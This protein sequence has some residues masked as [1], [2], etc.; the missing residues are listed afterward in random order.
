LKVMQI[1]ELAR[2]TS[3]TVQ[4]IRLYE[5]SGLLK[6]PSRSAGNYRVYDSE[7]LERLVFIRQC[8]ALGISI[9]EIATLLHRKETP[10][11]SC[12]EVNQLIAKHLLK[13]QEKICELQ[14]LQIT[15]EQLS[16][17]CSG[18]STIQTCGIFSKLEST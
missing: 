15:L 8:R 11:E 17:E 4:T 16:N 9:K 12:N 5:R 7:A 18:T 14:R 10:E 13:V 1:G 3:C 2:K 6:L